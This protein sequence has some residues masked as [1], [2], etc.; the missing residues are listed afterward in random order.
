MI[1]KITLIIACILTSMC[2]KAQVNTSNLL[3]EEKINQQL[4]IARKNGITADEIGMQK[5][6]LHQKLKQQNEA[7]VNGT[8][9]QKTIQPPPHINT[10][11]CTNPGFE[12][13]TSSDWTFFNGN[14]NGVNLPCNTCPTS[15]W[16]T[17]NTVVNATSTIQGQCNNGIDI[18]SGLPVVAPGA[19]G[20]SYSLLLNDASAGGKIQKAQYSFIANAAS[21]NYFTYQYAIVLQNGY[22]PMNEQAYFSV[23]MIDITTSSTIT[24]SSY[25]QSVPTSGAIAGWSTAANNVYYKPW[26]SISVDLT[27]YIGDSIAVNFVVSDCSQGGHFGYAYIDAACGTSSNV[28]Q[29]T[30]SNPLCTGGGITTLQ[31]PYGMSSYNWTGPVTGNSQNLVTGTAGTY[32]LSGTSATGCTTSNLYYT[33]TQLASAAPTVS[34]N[35]SNDTICAASTTTLTASGADTYTWSDNETTSA[36]SVSPTINT[37]YLVTG[38]DNT[39]GCVNTATQLIVIKQPLVYIGIASN[40]GYPCPGTPTTLTASGADTYTWSNSATTN[41]ITVSPLVNSNYGVTGT[42]TITGCTNTGI[43]FIT[44]APANVFI[45]YSVDSVC[46]GN[47]ATFTAGGATTYTWSTGETTASITVSPTVTTTYSVIATGACA[48]GANTDSITIKALMLPNVTIS[49]TALCAATVTLTANGANTYAWNLGYTTSTIIVSTTYADVYSVTGTGTNMCIDTA[50]ISIN[51]TSNN[52]IPFICMATTD[53]TTSYAYN[54][55]VWDKTA[56]TNV[57]SFFVYRW[58]VV[59][60]N[61]FKIGAVSVT[62]LSRFKDTAF[63]IGGPNGGNPQYASWQYKLAI[64]DSCGNIS[65]LSPYHQT[66]FVQQNG[67]NFTWNA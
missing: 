16:A 51:G 49:S 64:L 41:S 11:P 17:I 61:Y 24:C 29:I 38:T 66:M 53:S 31:G 56:Y 45:N 55:L 2:V 9:G 30:Q 57:D 58:D 47:S 20:G 33:L 37:T 34:V 60:T 59:S 26:S 5:K 3:S 25:Q 42:D 22:H 32:T 50:S 23:E 8:Y 15:S 44:V 43:I 7:I 46:I 54:Y 6:I 28:N 48:N 12:N 14:I 21:N 62:A 67:A 52:V 63:T 4:E 19:G 40:T 27:P 1:K 13:G 39:T 18:Y 65:P 10:S 36:I 35:A